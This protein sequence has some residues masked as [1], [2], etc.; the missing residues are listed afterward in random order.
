MGTGA[1]RDAEGVEPPSCHRP[2]VRPR[3]ACE[4][5]CT[6]D[7]SCTGYQFNNSNDSDAACAYYVSEAACPGGWAGRDPGGVPTY[8][9][10]TVTADAAVDCWRAVWA[11]LLSWVALEEGNSYVAALVYDA[12]TGSD[13]LRGSAVQT[14][15]GTQ[16]LFVPSLTAVLH[17]GVLHRLVLP[18]ALEQTPPGCVRTPAP[19]VLCETAEGE[20]TLKYHRNALRQTV[21]ARPRCLCMDPSCT[22]CP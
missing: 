3:E 14:V 17:R 6:E 10:Q 4:A 16:D 5:A 22:P 7:P 9:P 11:V 12:P 19:G 18:Q 20:A 1:C 15:Q 2:A 8:G 13:G 21:Y